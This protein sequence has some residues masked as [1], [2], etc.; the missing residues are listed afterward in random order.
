M[1]ARRTAWTGLVALAVGLV[2][3]AA[4]AQELTGELASQQDRQRRTREET[5]RVARRLETMLRVLVYYDVSKG[6]QQQLLGEAA[7]TLNALSKDQMAAVLAHLEAAVKAPDAASARAEQLRAYRKHRE[8]LA[9]LRGLLVKYAALRSLEQAAGRLAELSRS[10][11]EQHLRTERLIHGAPERGRRAFLDRPQEL[12]DMQED[13]AA[14]LGVLLQLLRDLEPLL[15]PEQKQRVE[16]ANALNRVHRLTHLLPQ[17]ARYLRESNTRKASPE[18]RDAAEELQA[19]ANDLRAPG[20]RLSELREARERVDQVLAEQRAIRDDTQDPRKPREQDVSTREHMMDLSGRQARNEYQ[21]RAARAL[22][23]PQSQEVARKIR[24]AERSMRQAGELLTQGD[25]K[26]PLDPQGIAEENLRQAREELDRM[27]A[28]EEQRRTD[29]LAALRHAADTVDRLIKDQADARR[30]TDEARAA[31]A[32]EARQLADPQKE[33][34]RRT[35]AVKEEPR[36]P[37]AAADQALDRAARAMA[38]AADAL[39]KP[40]PDAAVLKQDSALAALHE[41]KKALEEDLAAAEQRRQDIAALQ[42]AADKLD[43][44]AAK[45]EQIA[46]QAKE[47]AAD[48]GKPDPRALAGRQGELPPEAKP[49]ARQLDA[50]A[51]E[52]ARKIDQSAEKMESA[53]GNL[54]KEQIPPGARDARQA[55]DRLREAREELARALDALKAQEIAAQAAMQPNQVAPANAAVQIAKALEQARQA[56]QSARQAAQQLGP[57]PAQPGE[58]LARL[59]QQVADRADQMQLPPAAQSARQAAQAL[60]QADL[61][62]AVARQQQALDA[63]RQAAAAQ[64]GR[65]MDAPSQPGGMPSPQGAQDPGQL[66]RVQE[67]LLR[68]TQAMARSRQATNAAMAAAAQAQA[69]APHAVQGHLAEAQQQLGQA[70]RQLNQASP[71]QAGQSQQQAAAQLAQA[72]NTLNAAAAAMGQPG[73]QPGQPATAMASAQGQQ[74]QGQQGQGQGQGQQGQGQGQGQGKGQ[75]QKP[76]QGQGQGQAPGQGGKQPG[77]GPERNGNPGEGNRIPDGRLANIAAMLR[78]VQGRGGFIHLPPRER[79]MIDQYL[80][81]NAPPEFRAQIKQY[82]MNI[83]TGKPATGPGPA[84]P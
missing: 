4:H 9:G 51:P 42:D 24:E 74:G 79:A 47:M 40:N 46:G 45:Q 82:N 75:G 11:L 2:G 50:A 18:Q 58:D 16:K 65:P 68:A 52:A 32:D 83:A 5:D 26:R 53:R 57:Q 64:E 62:A 77:P 22:A 17:V 30:R 39:Q 78:E 63:L 55:S 8:V 1:S 15:S 35:E 56:A 49:L 13:L 29:P 37:N 20:D 7:A 36:V 19:I 73:A 33:L 43:R 38:Q 84:Q 66:A 3:V 72:L 80:Q 31:N 27:I 60:Q 70:G 61:S 28:R 59:Q 21:A 41:A 81:E 67:R 71:A 25:R 69:Q 76:G 14:E 10:E 6:E 23:E 44:L 34:A 54:Q 48:P 12:A